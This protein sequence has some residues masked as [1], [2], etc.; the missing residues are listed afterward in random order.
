M[1]DG[2]ARAWACCGLLRTPDHSVAL[3]S[4]RPSLALGFAAAQRS[5]GSRMR[6]LSGGAEAMSE[7]LS[8]SRC[9]KSLNW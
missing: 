8:T 5:D 1:T 3:S 9:Y 6:G 2:G 7:C 4:S